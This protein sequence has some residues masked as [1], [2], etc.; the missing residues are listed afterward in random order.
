MTRTFGGVRAGD[1]HALRWEALDTEDGR[2]AF[3]HVARAKTQRPDRLAI[4]EVLRPFV[5]QW[6][7]QWERPSEG[8]VFPVLTGDQAGKQAK[9]AGTSY[10]A[11]LRR[12]LQRAFV[13]ARAQGDESVPAKGLTALAGAV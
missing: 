7:Q 5:R 10:A 3:G 4:P 6:W 9:R 1:L 12:D 2:F 13:W 8:P 11:A